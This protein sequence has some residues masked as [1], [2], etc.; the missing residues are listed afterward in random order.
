MPFC[1]NCKNEYRKGFTECHECKVPLVE[2]LEEAEATPAIKPK[3]FFD[4]NDERSYEFL[5]SYIQ[6]EAAAKEAEEAEREAEIVSYGAISFTESQFDES[7]KNDDLMMVDSVSEQMMRQRQIADAMRR[8]SSYVDKKKM[9]EEYKSSGVVLTFVGVAGLIVLVLLYMGLIP[10]FSGFKSNYLFM[11]VM[12]VMF[13]A[14]IAGGISSFLQI[15]TIIIEAEADDDLTKRVND[16]M[17]EH[18]TVEKI[19]KEVV[20]NVSDADEELYFK[21]TAFMTRILMQKFPEMEEALR[22][23]LIDEK[24]GEL[25]EDNNN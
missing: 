25:Y 17:M 13:I 2:S 3:K 22:E 15:K 10:G 11:G 23:K 14:F 4:V 8:K 1:P 21:R 18:F 20:P 6:E 16:F 5:D 24:Y 7:K 9:I 12:S 19:A